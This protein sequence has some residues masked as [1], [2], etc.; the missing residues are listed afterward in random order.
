MPLSQWLRADLAVFA[1]DVLLSPSA[2]R[3]GVF[4]PRY[5]ERL[6]ALHDRGRDLDLQLW[7]I[8][9]VELWCRR[10]LDRT[11]AMPAGAASAAFPMAAGL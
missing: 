2:A 6:L 9:S 5:V 8:L 3:R 11:G 4:N 1:R 10:F 7:T